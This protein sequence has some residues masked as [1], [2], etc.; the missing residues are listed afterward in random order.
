[1]SDAPRRRLILLGSTGSIG[2]STLEVVAHLR[3]Q[4]LLDFEVV[5]LATGRNAAG[6]AEQ[7]RQHG[8]RHVA[9]ADAAAAASI[10][11][12]RHVYAGPDA[13]EQLVQAAARP[14][15]LVVGAMVGSAGLPAT[16]RAIERGCDVALANKE[17]LVAAGAIVMPLVK[18][19]GVHLLPVDSEHSAI[20]QCLAAGRG[21]QEV[22]RLVLTASGGPFRTWPPEKVYSASVE[23]ALDHPTWSMGPKVTVDSA[24]MT[25]KA[26][27]VIEAHWL[28]D[29]PPE[30]IQVSVHPQS[31][32]HSLVEF[33]DGSVIGQLSPPDMRSPI[34]YAL[35]WPRRLPGCAPRMDFTRAM[36]LE[37]EPVDPK[38]FPAVALAFEVVAAGGT[39]G[40]VFNAANEAAVEAFL[41]RRI[42]FGAIAE[43]VAG[44]LEAIPPVPVTS[45]EDVFAADRAAR[46]EVARRLEGARSRSP[47]ATRR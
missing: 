17:T 2:R 6:V 26:L 33:V 40:A 16:L 4:G 28:F 10:T 34:Q 44:A 22:K 29:M 35:T 21:P 15:D 43:L 19:T 39:A 9:V 7:A 23:E 36:R 42:P 45:L 31:I 27:E 3:R 5:G 8:A 41:A 30:R 20:F 1:M 18:R 47:C 14:G 32:I 37:F 46:D 11:D 13:A 25:N 24:S 38:R 12:V